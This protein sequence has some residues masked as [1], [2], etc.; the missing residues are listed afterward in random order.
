MADLNDTETITLLTEMTSS[1]GEPSEA[2]EPHYNSW[3]GVD[4]NSFEAQEGPVKS[5]G[6]A[7][8][9]AN[10][11]VEVRA[12]LIFEF[13]K[14]HMN[15]TQ[16][17]DLITQA[18]VLGKLL[19]K[20]RALGQDA[21]SDSLRVRIACNLKEQEFR[22]RG[23]GKWFSRSAIKKFQ[24]VANVRL[25]LVD[26]SHFSRPIP[27][28]PAALIQKLNEA[29]VFHR[30]MILHMNPTGDQALSFAER[31]KK[32]D[33]ILFGTSQYNDDRLFYITDWV[34]EVCDLTMDKLLGAIHT[35]DAD[36][37]LSEVPEVSETDLA[38]EMLVVNERM[39]RYRATRPSTY[40]GD[41]AVTSL[42]DQP[43][44]WKLVGRLIRALWRSAWKKRGHFDGPYLG[45]LRRG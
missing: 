30:L 31:I 34:D 10:G 42:E 33:P 39:D 13:I 44:S 24:D 32:K 43:F 4:S 26:L 20:A 35:Y 12:D 11:K 25:E 38:K 8:T 6:G 16:V 21:F 2:D 27:A 22:V 36:F 5:I 41:V 17:H 28:I 37:K 18:Q 45:S 9:R 7:E 3:E 15:D 40:R 19:V 29:Q 1:G 23:Y 14:A